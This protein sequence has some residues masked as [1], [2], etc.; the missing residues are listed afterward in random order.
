MKIDTDIYYERVCHFCGQ[1]IRREELFY[2]NDEVCC[3]VYNCNRLKEQLEN[4]YNELYNNIE[5]MEP[6]FSKTIDKHFWRL[7]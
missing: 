7:V 6:R 3:H 2:T 5:D 4:I 1:V